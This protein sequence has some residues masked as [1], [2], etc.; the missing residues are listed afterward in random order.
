MKI[1]VDFEERKITLADFPE[2]ADKFLDTLDILAWSG[3]FT[4]SIW[5]YDGNEYSSPVHLGLAI[6]REQDKIRRENSGH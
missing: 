2:D 6:A 4:G 1:Y 3:V 5:V